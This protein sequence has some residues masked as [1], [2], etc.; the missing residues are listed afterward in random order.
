MGIPLDDIYKSNSDTLKAAD[1]KREDGTPIEVQVTI[2][3][4]G[5]IDYAKE[6]EDPKVQVLLGLAGKDKGFSLNKTNTDVIR[7]AY[8]DNTDDW[9][10]KQIVIF[11]TTTSY[12]GRSVPCLRCRA[13]LETASSDEDIPF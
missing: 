7:A 6:G 5:T 13:V 10:G 1:L 2:S 12:E 3:E 11:P 4:V 9:I 8:G